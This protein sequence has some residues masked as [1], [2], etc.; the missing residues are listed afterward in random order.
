MCTMHAV[1]KHN[2]NYILCRTKVTYLLQL[3]QQELTKLL[4]STGDP[5]V[6]TVDRMHSST[7]QCLNSGIFYTYHGGCNG[8][9]YSAAV[10]LGRK[11][12]YRQNLTSHTCKAW[13]RQS[14]PVLPKEY[15]TRGNFR[16]MKFSRYYTKTEFYFRSL[17]VKG[18]AVFRVWSCLMVPDVYE[19]YNLL[20]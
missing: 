12:S 7:A 4:P 20:L 6:C 8:C 15:H 11:V 19:R 13:L 18:F 17:S 3:L 14:W 10:A 1:N 9:P 5:T 2:N 16:S